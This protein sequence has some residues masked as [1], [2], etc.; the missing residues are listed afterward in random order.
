MAIQ[1][2][3]A[4]GRVLEF[5][6]GTDT[7]VIQQT[8]KNMIAQEQ[9]VQPTQPQP[10]DQATPVQP[11]EQPQPQEMSEAGQAI[12]DVPGGAA[13][14]EFTSA[15]NRG[16]VNL[17]DFIGPEQINNVLQ[18]IGSDKRVPTLGE[19]PAV[20]AATTGEFME[21]GLA[22]QAIRTGGEFVGPGAAVG[23]TIRAAAQQIPKVAAQAPTVAQRVLQSA[24]SKPLPE[25]AATATAG[26]GSEVGAEVG[27][28][29]GGAEG[30]Q[31]GRMAGG[32]IAPIGATLAKETAKT[33]IS[34]SAKKLLGQAAPTIQGLKETARGVFKEIDNLGVTVNPSSTNRLS[35]ELSTLTRRQ[36]F[37]P[38]IHPKVNAALKE[39]ESVAGQTQSLSEIDTLR[40]VAS[41]AAKSIEPD[42]ARL[43]NM[44]INK[45]DDFLDTAGRNE[46]QGTTKNIGAK[47]RDARQ[48]WRRA[49]K[50]EQIE[51]AF[52]KAQLQATGFENGIRTQFRQ[53]LN[54]KKQRKGF[55]KDELDAMRQVVKG[56]TLQNTAKM[57]GRFGFSEGQASNML[58]GSLGVA[59]GAAV[60]G[61]AG[62]VAVPL[63]GNLSRSLA[64]KLTRKGAESTD[65]IV[66]AGNSGIEI[67]KAYLK[68]VPAKER[69]AQE[70]TELLLRP[71]ISLKGLKQ[72][73]KNAGRQSRK[74]I[75]D[76]A[77]LTNAIKS[78]QQEQQ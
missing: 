39:F 36:G 50:S 17:L 55:T 41:A 12:L 74:L 6:D 11:L 28:A 4:D 37:N 30:R 63:I 14:T 73:V 59:G 69:S 62:A 46:L 18:L 27:E 5:P 40:R 34:P 23:Q 8:V 72:S 51:E 47:Y 16:A 9:P 25:A 67:T 21:P 57:I 70:L 76:A 48:L 77:F 26:A 29:I 43:G 61:P 75:N 52:N 64:Q 71:N 2:Q 66:R 24:V 20:Q 31:I 19:Q 58:M 54:S 42:E 56:T 45:I 15:V 65:L 38:T 78:S 49:K 68:S 35:A 3:L 32:I 44:M 1:A 60:G 13:L 33:L 10:M 7:A 22:R 53:I